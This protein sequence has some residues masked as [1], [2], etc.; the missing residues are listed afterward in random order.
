MFGADQAAVAY[1]IA[2]SLCIPS[3]IVAPDTA[4]YP[5]EAIG[6]LSVTEAS[7]NCNIR[8]ATSA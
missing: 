6:K 7:Q 5:N 8:V 4:I 2:T 1:D 3:T